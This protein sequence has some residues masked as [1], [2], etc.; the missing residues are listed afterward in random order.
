MKKLAIVFCLM[1]C[2]FA[3]SSKCD[4]VV[5]EDFQGGTV[6][7]DLSTQG[8]Y[9]TAGAS[10]ITS[11]QFTDA[12]ISGYDISAR[13]TAADI[14]AKMDFTNTV[15]DSDEDVYVKII[16]TTGNQLIRGG[17][18]TAR[19]GLLVTLDPVNGGV[20]LTPANFASAVT[21]SY[22]ITNN[23]TYEIVVQM[24][25]INHGNSGSL[26][27]RNISAGETEYT[28]PTELQDV[29]MNFTD[30]AGYSKPSTLTSL[31]VRGQYNGWWDYFE[32]GTGMAP[33]PTPVV[34][35]EDFEG[36]IVGDNLVTDDWYMLYGT[37]ENNIK[38]NESSWTGYG[39]S[40][41]YRNGVAQAMKN[42][43]NII[44]DS[45]SDLYAKFVAHFGNQ[46]MFFGFRGEVRP[47]FFLKVMPGGDITLYSANNGATYTSTD[48]YQ[49]STY[50]AYEFVVNFTN[51][52]D[53][54]KGWVMVRN[55]SA[56]EQEYTE[57]EGLQDVSLNFSHTTDFTKPSNFKGFY[58][59]GAYNG[60]MEHME[61]G[62]GTAVLG[63]NVTL[64]Q[65]DFEDATIGNTLGDEG[66][67]GLYNANIQEWYIDSGFNDTI[68]AVCDYTQ[69]AG[70]WAKT[71]ADPNELEFLED[72]MDIYFEVDIVPR[73]LG[74][75]T[76]NNVYAGIRSIDINGDDFPAF[77]VGFKRNETDNSKWDLYF[78]NAL[79]M[80]A[81]T[82]NMEW[83]NSDTVIYNGHIYSFRVQIHNGST[84]FVYFKNLTLNETCWTPIPNMQ[85]IPMQFLQRSKPE[86]FAMWYLRGSYAPFEVD[87]F[88][89]GTGL[90]NGCDVYC[91]PALSGL[92]GDLNGDCYVDFE[93]INV[94][95]TNWLYSAPASLIENGDFSQ[96][97]AGTGL[98]VG[99][100]Y[101]SWGTDDGPTGQHYAQVEDGQL[102]QIK[103]KGI[104][105]GYFGVYQ[106]F[107]VVPGRDYTITA[108]WSGN[109][110][111]NGWAEMLL[112][113]VNTSDPDIS[114][115]ATQLAQGHIV[116]KHDG[117][118]DT[119]AIF[120]PEPITNA[121]YHE[122]CLLDEV[123]GGTNVR[124]ATTPYMVVRTNL[125]SITPD[126]SGG[127]H[128]LY[129]DNITITGPVPGDA[130][131]DDDVNIYDYSEIADEWLT[132]AMGPY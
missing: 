122:H 19:P 67:V 97:D 101:V 29:S 36:G 22:P 60:K 68:S 84:A 48:D 23:T 16:M 118:D 123:N 120:G 34:A 117:M 77:H 13:P 9:K 10:E 63:E 107:E 69:P 128:E 21:V 91:D 114:D 62:F 11:L 49:I 6:G 111:D 59:R 33:E 55:I 47:G 81:G 46:A 15:T 30:T 104:P 105:T 94:L 38:F 113:S 35:I 115:L 32:Y 89:L 83:T 17:L 126:I 40:A 72:E 61:L 24:K 51:I 99:W 85:G 129:I 125:G 74:D 25:N 106:V 64:A 73:K 96:V 88:E 100:N 43:D 2:V 87:N 116:S 80:P 58:M 109:V 41:L 52:N 112:Y 66:W 131:E 108:D 79:T 132:E 124:T 110:D 4:M 76:A 57:L 50:K 18:S 92:S 5:S 26:K 20:T 45:A 37:S 82:P 53:G 27:I 70:Q 103:E 3:A 65:E 56:G 86:F 93:D 78:H 7:Q 130:N 102:V 71:F 28:A 98:P 95:A 119:N 14:Q 31:W 127:I 44:S 8:W 1:L 12:W 54:G 90:L 121:M 75:G 39:T 42:F